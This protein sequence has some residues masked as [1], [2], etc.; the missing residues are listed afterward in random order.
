ML[1]R[2]L[3][4]LKSVSPFLITL[5]TKSSK[6]WRTQSGKF[7]L[8]ELCNE[9][10]LLKTGF[11]SFDRPI[12]PTKSHQFLF[13]PNKLIR[14]SKDNPNGRGNRDERN[15]KFDHFLFISKWILHYYKFKM[16]FRITTSNWRFINPI[17]FTYYRYRI[18]H[19]Y[20]QNHLYQLVLPKLAIIHF[21]RKWKKRIDYS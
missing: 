1:T 5:S 17:R 4:Y 3:K 13:I 2:Y 14:L 8:V 11:K 19:Q 6:R 16:P 18:I 10:S 15:L 12:S 9:P 20:R 21:L 7:R